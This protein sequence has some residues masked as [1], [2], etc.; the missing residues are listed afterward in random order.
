MKALLVYGST[1]GNTAKVV[2][3]VPPLLSFPVDIVNIRTLT[4]DSTFA[5]YDL[6]LFF[7]STTGDQELQ[8]DME[9]F[10]VRQT[11]N[12]YGKPYAVCELGNY[13]GYDDFDLGAEQILR[14]LLCQAGGK[15]LIPPFCMD[16]FPYKDWNNLAR[17]CVHLNQAAS[18]L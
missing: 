12:L 11:R 13:F 18:E 8:E 3:R 4:G 7:A 2:Q 10:F 6:L 5:Q 16:S 14:H 15:E 9:Q 1:W 17:W